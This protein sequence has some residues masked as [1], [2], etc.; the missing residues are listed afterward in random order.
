[1]NKI[2]RRI[3]PWFSLE[4]NLKSDGHRLSIM[5][6]PFWSVLTPTQRCCCS[7]TTV[8]SEKR[9]KLNRTKI[10]LCSKWT[11]LIS[12][13]QMFGAIRLIL[14]KPLSWF[15]RCQWKIKNINVYFNEKCWWLS[16]YSVKVKH[17]HDIW[18]NKR[19]T[20]QMP[21]EIEFPQTN[22]EDIDLMSK[23]NFWFKF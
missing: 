12:L 15:K 6:F 22:K 11:E 10:I 16:I 8:F 1:M 2:F 3:S 20:E 9:S 5:N 13:I 7:T 23:M 18:K 14:D 21:Y 19:E 17:T 4:M